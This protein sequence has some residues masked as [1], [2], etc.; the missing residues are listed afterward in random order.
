MS[1]SNI[2]ELKWQFLSSSVK[3]E[4]NSIL[5][6]LYYFKTPSKVE[7]YAC[8]RIIDSCHYT[9]VFGSVKDLTFEEL[10]QKHKAT[11]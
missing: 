10:L 8:Y 5:L 4:D 6:N 3:L 7:N 2:K 9:L 1:T 11:Q